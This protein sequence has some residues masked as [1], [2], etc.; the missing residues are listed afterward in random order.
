MVSYIWPLP[1]T[2]LCFHCPT[3]G[4]MSQESKNH[5]PRLHPLGDGDLSGLRDNKKIR[6]D[7]AGQDGTQ[8]HRVQRRLLQSWAGGGTRLNLALQKA[9]RDHAPG[10]T[11]TALT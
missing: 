7:I 10:V 4:S 8:V 5:L 2:L 1:S 11:A 9:Q 6:V 3:D